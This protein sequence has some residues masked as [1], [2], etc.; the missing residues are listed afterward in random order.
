MSASSSF[1]SS[2]MTERLQQFFSHLKPASS[3]LAVASQRNPNDVVITLAVRTPLTKARKGGMRDT[4][5]ERML[6]CLYQA[7]HPKDMAYSRVFLENRKSNRKQ[8]RIS[9]WETSSTLLQDIKSE[10]QLWRQDSPSRHPQRVS[11][12]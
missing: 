5:L 2:I 10:Q 4:T 7:S 11:T 1:P 9:F 6:L 12:D 8:F 3:G